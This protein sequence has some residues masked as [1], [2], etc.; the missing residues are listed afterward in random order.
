MTQED[1]WGIALERI[2]RE[3]EEKTGFLD[4]GMLALE[5][6]PGEI[7]GLTH[8]RGLN[9]GHHWRNENDDWHEASGQI[10]D[11][12]LVAMLD[13]ARPL[14]KLRTLSLRGTKIESLSALK[15]CATLQSLDCSGTQVSD[16]APLR[17]LT[18]LQSLDCC[19]TQVSDLGPLRGLAALQ[20]LLCSGT[21][22]SDLAPL[23]DLAVLQLLHCSGTQVSDL[24][25]LCGLAT[26]RSLH[27]AYTQ[28]SDLVM[29]ES[30]AA[31]QSLDCSGTQ[32]KSLTPLKGLR[33]L[34]SLFCSGTEV[35]DLV[36]LQGLAA[37]QVID[38]SGTQ[39][40]DLKPLKDL[41][42]LQS[43]NCSSTQVSNL[44]PLHA[45]RAMESLNCFN[46]QVS[47]IRPLEGI[48]ALKSLNCAATL[49][50]DL[51]PLKSL[52]KLAKLDGCWLVLDA[53]PEWL[54]DAP[55]SYV[56]RLYRSRV[57]GVPAEILSQGSSDNC[58]LA[59]R[60]HF[61]D[62]AAGGVPCGDVKL[63][64]LG[65]GRIGKTQLCNRLRGA[66]FEPDADS[67][68]GI[69]VETLKLPLAEGKD[70]ARLH[71]WD[72][73]GQDIYHGAHALFLRA[74]ALFLLV[75]TQ[76][77][78]AR[79][80][81]EHG[82]MIFR[83]H[84]LRY[85]VDYVRHLGGKNLAALIVQTRCDSFR[86]ER[87]C[88]VSEEDL[89]EAFADGFRQR[90]EFSARTDRGLST[91]KEKLAEAVAFLHES[92]GVAM[93]GASRHRVKL[94]LEALRDEDAHREKH[95]KRHR[96]IEQE[97]FQS[98]CEEERLV[99]EPKYLLAY[100]HNAGV[101][102]YREGL[103]GDRIILDQSW[104]LEAVYAV[105]NRKDCYNQLRQAKGRFTRP[106]LASLV[107]RDH[108][109]QEQQLFLDMMK[110]CGV[111]FVLREGDPDRGIEAEYAAPALL[112]RKEEVQGELGALWRGGEEIAPA[113]YAYE[114][115]HPGLI[116][117]VTSRIGREAGVNAVYWQGGLCFYETQM[118]AVA[119][120]EE[121]MDAG[122]SGR[123]VL[124]TRDGRAAELMARLQGIV[125]AEQDRI[126]LVPREAPAR[127][128]ARMQGEEQ[129]EPKEK[130]LAIG[131][132]PVP[133]RRFYVSYAWRDASDESREKI[134]DRLCAAAEARGEPII[135]DKTAVNVGDS[136]SRFMQDIG[137]GERIFVILSQKYLESPFCIYELYLVWIDSKCDR[138]EFLR[139]V[140]V[141]AL[142]DAK[143]GDLAERGRRAKY[144]K[145]KLRS[146]EAAVEGDT[147]LFGAAGR[148]EL[149]LMQIF[150][151]HLGDI[152]D[153]LADIR[154]PRSFEE[155]MKYGFDDPPG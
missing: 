151:Y 37:L 115:L 40:S 92:E 72:F 60:A 55:D 94:R 78:E 118:R 41:A 101:V 44:A 88:P 49:V 87:P 34:Q 20:S 82:G 69:V 110:S 4:L 132:P 71:I 126:G 148:E 149:R 27:C 117:A 155:L 42:G 120:I 32:V 95:D 76:A 141:Y 147:F 25:P 127:A 63:M 50:R 6:L 61:A 30:L 152:L 139:R 98:I 11:N 136:I 70:P 79:G 114:L 102:F 112:P 154:Q 89:R 23:Q 57:K 77:F 96:W 144:W 28:L 138:K 116:R 119:L 66:P 99:S 38:C 56:L 137:K 2:R 62:L 39:V 64:V 1:G 111:C 109:P 33:A 45:L 26:L 54:L 143:I 146:V 130:P 29:L 16:L 5:R 93:I 24:T 13:G 135:R 142:D 47:D 133:G 35:S 17:G 8:L 10:G 104:A 123:I 19:F 107:W 125:E 105:F 7:L 74:N 80:T 86:D 134:V 140:R 128:A 36:P 103:F 122:W 81:H 31:L 22:V 106:L 83:N 145:D 108:A 68:H 73:G 153:A 100:L 21:Q 43:L 91:L 58:L 15:H 129:G 3:A 75:W 131:S 59:A 18:A 90:I 84:P 65:N 12:R 51:S 121:Q 113:I 9:L 85:W 150:A 48:I 52:E 53:F 97:E 14:P 67:T 124:R 46:T